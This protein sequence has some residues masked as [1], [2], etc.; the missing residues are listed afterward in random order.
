ML[1]WLRQSVPVR[2]KVCRKLQKEL[3]PCRRRTRAQQ[4]GM[5]RH[6]PEDTQSRMPHPR[7]VRRG[8]GGRGSR[9]AVAALAHGQEKVT[10]TT[11]LVRG[12]HGRMVRVKVG[13]VT[14]ARTAC[15]GTERFYASSFCRPA[16]R[17][18]TSSAGEDPI[19]RAAA[20]QGPRQHERNRARHRSLKWPHPGDGQPEARP[21]LQWR[22]ALLHHQ[23]HR[24][25]GRPGRRSHQAR[26][27]GQPRRRIQGGRSPMRSPQ[28]VNPYFETLGRE[29]G[30]ERVKHYANQFGLG[31]LAGYH[32]AG[33]Q[34]GARTR[35]R[36]SRRRWAASAAC[37]RS[38][39]ASA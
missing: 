30:F 20:I 25:A 34:L 35:I 28:S 26:H 5:P 36:S 6:G 22:R 12:R 23:A 4:E 17:P 13:R 29:L 10:V 2:Q 7:A 3:E 19:V 39:R 37:V 21:G 33:E 1:K 32:I 24:G 27:A 15:R 18:A 11:R 9:E 8:R 38:A 31:E 14:A 16:D